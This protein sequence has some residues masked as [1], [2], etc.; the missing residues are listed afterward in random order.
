MRL[1]LLLLMLAAPT[2][3]ADG[4]ATPAAAG[5]ATPAFFT[6]AEWTAS[7]PRPAPVGGP[8]LGAVAGVAGALL[9]VAAL[10]VGL[11]WLAKRAGVNRVMP[12]R[13]AHL[14]VVDT[15][16]MGFKRSLTLVKLGDQLVLVGQAEQGMQALGT[17][18]A[19]LIA[20]PPADPSAPP[21]PPAEPPPSAFANLLKQLQGRRS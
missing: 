21:A 6:D 5:A 4:P 7:A 1:L 13:G 15:L 9:A 16:P 8:G 19:S 18:P 14:E 12:R 11:G 17:F 3:C 20:P 10:A 2:W